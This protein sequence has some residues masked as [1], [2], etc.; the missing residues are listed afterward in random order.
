MERSKDSSEF[1]RVIRPGSDGVILSDRHFKLED[2]N[3]LTSALI[4]KSNGRLNELQEAATV[5]EGRLKQQVDRGREYIEDAIK[6]AQSQIQSRLD[7][8]EIE[9]KRVYEDRYREGLE[10]GH[11]EGLEKG[12]SE[13]YEQGFKDG[14]A[15]GEE[16]GISEGREA[17]RKAIEEEMADRYRQET[18]DAIVSVRT[19]SSE[20]RGQ[21]AS[22]LQ[23]SRESLL[24]LSLRL[25]EAVIKERIETAPQ[26]I[27]ATLERA[28][29]R[30]DG[31]STIV[32]EVHPDDRATIEG[33]LDEKLE[34]ILNDASVEIREVESIERGGLSVRSN[35]TVVDATIRGQLETM[36][37]RLIESGGVL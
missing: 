23:A 1:G 26:L 34:E 18:E 4:A 30:I 7:H 33:F 24:D 29:E 3:E 14:Y 2:I 15:T 31:K 35:Q 12:T 17:G 25:A 27:V 37:E 36:R 5:I 9:T 28:L 20:L 8:T 16:K 21:W 32:I 22:S 10:R 19:L 13:G 6:L 11:R